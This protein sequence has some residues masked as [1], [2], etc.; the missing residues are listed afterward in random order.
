ME[1]MKAGKNMC[2]VWKMC[3]LDIAYE[4]SKWTIQLLLTTSQTSTALLLISAIKRLLQNPYLLFQFTKRGKSAVKI[5]HSKLPM[6]MK[7][8]FQLT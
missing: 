5:M 4:S 8:H 6:Y 1:P 7:P 2:Q 3:N